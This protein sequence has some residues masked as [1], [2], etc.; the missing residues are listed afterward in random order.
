VLKERKKKEENKSLNILDFSMKQ[1]YTEIYLCERLEKKNEKEQDNDISGLSVFD[2]GVS[3]SYFMSL[4]E[5]IAKKNCQYKSFR[6]S[7]KTY[8]YQDLF[9]ENRDEKDIEVYE[10]KML[11][12]A[13]DP[14]QQLMH[15]SYHKKKESFNVFPSTT[16]LNAIMHTNR[17]SF[18]VNSHIYINFD[19]CYHIEEKRKREEKMDIDDLDDLCVYKVFVNLNTEK[20][21]DLQNSKRLIQNAIDFVRE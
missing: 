8:C 21:I 1:N 18:L 7:F 9:M 6:K 4:I 17:L 11:M 19:V 20:N 15:I 5:N 13:T 10:K 16:N 12:Y 14:D 2:V 3:K